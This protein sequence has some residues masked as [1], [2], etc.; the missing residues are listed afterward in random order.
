MKYIGKFV[1]KTQFW[2]DV[3]GKCAI[4]GIDADRVWDLTLVELLKRW[5]IRA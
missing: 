5:I 4:V 2:R 3:A 1:S